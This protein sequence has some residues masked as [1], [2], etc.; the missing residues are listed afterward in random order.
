MRGTPG[1]DALADVA[2]RTGMSEED[3]LD[4][5]LARSAWKCMV[6]VCLSAGNARL[7]CS[8]TALPALE[9]LG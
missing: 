1:G 7:R 2:R 6:T 9:N 8:K 4:L 5:R 3:V